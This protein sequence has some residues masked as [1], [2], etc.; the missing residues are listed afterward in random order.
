MM[1]FD[2]KKIT[3]KL[4]KFNP[5]QHNKSVTHGIKDELTQVNPPKHNQCHEIEITQ[6]KRKHKKSQR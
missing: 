5:S 1:K 6:Q 3:K 2:N 4:A